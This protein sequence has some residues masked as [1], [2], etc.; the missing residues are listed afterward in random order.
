MAFGYWHLSKSIKYPAIIDLPIPSVPF[1][2]VIR[3]S[4]FPSRSE[5]LQAW[6]SGIARAHSS[7]PALRCFRNE[8]NCDSTSQYDGDNHCKNSALGCLSC[9]YFMPIVKGCFSLKMYS[10]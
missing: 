1:I 10:L 9:S 7:V 3:R 4:G 5:S 2:Q 8:A 6:N